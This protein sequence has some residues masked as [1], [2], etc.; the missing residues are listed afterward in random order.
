ML[1]RIIVIVH[2]TIIIDN[3]EII[4]IIEVVTLS[5]QFEIDII[6]IFIGFVVF[7]IVNE[8]CEQIFQKDPHKMYV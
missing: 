4:A 3:G 6:G 5:V 2:I 8:T 1:L 7:I